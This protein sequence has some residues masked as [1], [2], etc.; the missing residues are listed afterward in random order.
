M[1][2]IELINLLENSFSNPAE[3]LGGNA[4]IRSDI[5]QRDILDEFR[6]FFQ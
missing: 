6:V 1:N 2:I 5:F 3:R 4:N